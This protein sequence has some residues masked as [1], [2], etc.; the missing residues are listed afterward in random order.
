MS[1]KS[2]GIV[3]SLGVFGFLLIL[4]GLAVVMYFGFGDAK[5]RAAKNQKPG[6][7]AP[8]KSWLR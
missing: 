7:N 8:K 5:D 3:S 2:G 4:V 1:K 6:D